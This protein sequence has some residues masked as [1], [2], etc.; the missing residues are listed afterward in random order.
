MSSA[1][2]LSASAALLASLPSIL[3]SAAQGGGGGG[4]EVGGGGL[5]SGSSEGSGCRCRCPYGHQRP[6]ESHPTC[7]RV[8][9]NLTPTRLSAVLGIQLI[10]R[11][12][13]HAGR[14]AYGQRQHSS[15]YARTRSLM[16]GRRGCA[17][18]L[19]H[20][21]F[22]SP[23]GSRARPYPIAP[24]KEKKVK[25]YPLAPVPSVSAASPMAYEHRAAAG[26]GGWE[27][28]D[29]RKGNGGGVRRGAAGKCC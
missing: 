23:R 17:R 9:S 24:E 8:A 26:Q 19:L 20:P 27:G 12:Q 6:I 5:G 22:A 25:E 29:G 13:L 3:P 18:A 10:A 21:S 1:S 2:N 16:Q 7:D 28:E 15:G 11:A 4:V 14:P